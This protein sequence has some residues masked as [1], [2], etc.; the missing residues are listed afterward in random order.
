M[1]SAEV[2]HIVPLI[3]LRV[4]DPRLRHTRGESHQHAE[5]ERPLIKM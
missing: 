5:A 3:Q 1:T 2:R 4:F